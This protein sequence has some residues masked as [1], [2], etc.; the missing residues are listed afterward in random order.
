MSNFRE[1]VKIV[2]D[3]YKKK[4][5]RKEYWTYLLILIGMGTLY[6]AFFERSV[7]SPQT[8]W[9]QY[10]AWRTSE[11]ELP[12]KDFFLYVPP[13]FLLITRILFSIFGNHFIWYTIIGFIFTRVLM[14]ILVYNILSKFLHPRTTAMGIF[15]GICI[16]S[17]Y[18]ADQCYDYN[19]LVLMLA[20]LIAYLLQKISLSKNNNIVL[21]GI[22]TVG[23]ICATELF[24]K[25]NVG[26]IMPILVVL[27]ILLLQY[28][29]RTPLKVLLKR[30]LV[31]FAGFITGILPGII[32]LI[33]NDIVKDCLNCIVNAISAKTAN[34]NFLSVALKNFINVPALIIALLLVSLFFIIKNKLMQSNKIIRLLLV[35]T[36]VLTVLNHFSFVLSG[37]EQG[38]TRES[39]MFLGVA[40]TLSIV[41][42]Y[43]L[44]KTIDFSDKV[45]YIVWFCLI[46]GFLF[47]TKLNTTQAELLYQGIQFA[48]LKS[49][50]LYIILYVDLMF[51]AYMLYQ[52]F[53]K[54]N[55][56][57]YVLLFPSIIL[58]LFMG[59]S[60]ISA[61]LEELYAA[62][63]IPVFV[64]IFIEKVSEHNYFKN[65]AIYICA[66]TLC[67]ICLSEK[68]LIPY[69]WHSWSLEN[70]LSDDNPP[71]KINIKGLEGFEIAKSD[72]TAYEK[73]VKTIEENSEKDDVLYQFPNILL[74]N[75]LTERKTIYGAVPYFDVCPDDLAV[76]SAEYLKKNLPELVLYSEL[77]EER[78]NIHELYFRNGET[79]GQRKIQEF[80]NDIVKNNYRQLGWYNNRSGDPLCLWKKTAYITGYPIRSVELKTNISITKNIKFKKDV[81]DTFC[82]NSES[83]LEGK[84]VSIV[85]EDITDKE[86]LFEETVEL[87]N[88]G[89]NYY[90]SDLGKIT[91]DL[92]HDYRIQ[93]T[94]DWNLEQESIFVGAIGQN[95][96]DFSDNDIC[97]SLD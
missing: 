17:S 35:C 36:T 40:I 87:S 58:I 12:Y 30:L 63:I 33:K 4:Y 95:E 78:W 13:Y 11:G 45:Y 54:S 96:A 42:L 86:V 83:N 55:Y 48:S 21:W 37:L 62:I 73:I 60:F 65:I 93:V 1:G 84:N 22:F 9:W 6:Y 8:G 92:S 39:L 27:C 97:I 94:S 47:I 46:L 43:I 64:G 28:F 67:L 15:C 61:K 57:Y 29:E 88:T 32:Y 76:E 25:Q 71:S 52:I 34:S 81:I 69:D 14:W 49:N 80:Y 66:F 70:L 85:I 7:I 5:T 31:F 10:M 16:T 56:K 23:I 68:L 91:T 89:L 20:I 38:L 3:I 82:I 2:I 26:I 18:L 74:F 44:N 90:K 41:I 72:A 24:M 75:V 53:L 59:S 19:P 51:W 50:L 77:N 79:S